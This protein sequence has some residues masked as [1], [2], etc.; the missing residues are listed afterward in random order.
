MTKFFFSFGGKGGGGW[1]W[2][3]KERR[4]DRIYPNWG[5]LSENEIKKTERK[6]RKGETRKKERKQ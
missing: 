5:F 6:N 3:R 1:V 4:K 2:W